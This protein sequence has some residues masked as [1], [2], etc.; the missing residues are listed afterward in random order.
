MKTILLCV[1]ML[2]LFSCSKENLDKT[3]P[4]SWTIVETN[5][6]DGSGYAIQTYT[7]SS[8]I[9]IEFG[10]GG[11]LMLTGSNPGT[12][13]SPLWEYDRY[14]IRKDNTIRFYQSTGSKEMEAYYSVEGNLFLNYLWARCGYEEQFLRVR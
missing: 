2:T 3:I 13:M 5:I 10:A 4:G 9:T 12:A 8:E 7:P 1:A 14:Q 11:Q 6:G